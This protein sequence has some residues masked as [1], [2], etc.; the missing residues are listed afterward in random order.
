MCIP[1]DQS[2]SPSKTT[3]ANPKE[4]VSERLAVLAGPGWR[5]TAGCLPERGYLVF[6]TGGPP[7]GFSRVGA[8]GTLVVYSAL[9]SHGNF[10][11]NNQSELNI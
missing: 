9:D 8:N 7:P 4:L 2:L 10:S 3:K 11:L 5:L 1:S 6:E